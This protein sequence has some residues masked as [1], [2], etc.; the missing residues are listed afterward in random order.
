MT[1]PTIDKAALEAAIKA[2]GNLNGIGALHGEKIERAIRA[3]LAAINP[4]GPEL[5]GRQPDTGVWCQ[6]DDGTHAE[7]QV[8]KFEAIYAAAGWTDLRRTN[9]FAL[10]ALPPTTDAVASL[11]ISEVEPVAD[12]D[13]F[14][15]RD[16]IDLAS[17]LRSGHEV[18][19]RAALSNNFNVVLA[20]LDR[21]SA[22]T[23]EG[24]RDG[25]LEEAAQLCDA[26]AD[27]R[28]AQARKADAGDTS[29]GVD[30]AASAS[31]QDNKAITARAL[32]AAIRALKG[33]RT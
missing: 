23:P 9:P 27:K 15:A 1:D 5:W 21:C 3:Y 16:F 24:V 20:A 33:N 14:V 7:E 22:R 4:A 26:E 6:I 8:A 13:G 19:R 30:L 11:N 2:Y 17:Q 10:A 25:V 31:A 18:I 28:F 12:D 29:W 32:G